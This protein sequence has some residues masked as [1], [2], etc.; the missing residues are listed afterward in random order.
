MET[1]GIFSTTAAFTGIFTG[2]TVIFLYFGAI[3]P[4]GKLTLYFMASL[5]VAITI[6]E[7]GTGAGISVYFAACMLSA[8]MGG[9]ILGIVPFA[10][11]FGHYPIFKYYIEKGRKAVTEVMLKLVVFNASW[12]LWYLLFESLFTSV[13]PTQF[14][15]SSALFAAFIAVLQVI[16]FIYDYIFSRLL[17]YYESKL[18][19]VR[20]R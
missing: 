8:L 12:L 1:S 4:T 16:F 15:G 9:N 2:I 19:M 17:F 11:F 6:V 18:S 3:V 14:T 7:F 13:I 20:K 5:P 10:L